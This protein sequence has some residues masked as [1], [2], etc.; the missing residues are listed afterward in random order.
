LWEVI[1]S[2]YGETNLKIIAKYFNKIIEVNYNSF[3]NAN[4]YTSYIQ[5]IVLYLKELGHALPEFF[6]TILLFKRLSNS[7]DSFSSRKYK[8][9]VNELKNNSNKKGKGT[10]DTLLINISK[11]VSDIISEES[12]ISNNED[13]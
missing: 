6:I 2:I 8:E 10:E 13:S 9:I 7:F 1:I 5:F 4:E 3:K 11:L 12:R